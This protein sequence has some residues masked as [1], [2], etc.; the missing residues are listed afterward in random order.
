ME[1][2]M[3][4]KKLIVIAHIEQGETHPTYHVIGGDEVALF[5]V[6]DNAPNDRVYEVLS[7]SNKAILNVFIPEGT[8]IG[9]MNDERHEAISNSINSLIEG[10]PRF[11]V[12]D[13]GVEDQ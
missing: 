10:R 1:I 2:K 4:D 8:P 13:G 6:D 11:D 3:K 7:R 5:V 9:S 12:I